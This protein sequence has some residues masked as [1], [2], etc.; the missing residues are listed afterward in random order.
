V[1][2]VNINGARLAYRV[3]GS[4]Q[5]PCVVL[6]HCLGSDSRMW[7][8][9]VAPLSRQ[10]RVVR[11]DCRGHGS[12]DLSNGQ[13]DIAGLGR[14]LV[15]LL[16]HLQIDRAHVCG[17]SLGGVIAQW[18]VVHYPERVLSAVFANTAARIGSTASWDA[19]IEAVR[20]RGMAG[21]C[22]TLIGR[23][24]STA[25]RARRPDVVRI[26][27]D[28]LQAT[29][30]EGYIAACA[31]LRDADLCA[32]VPSIRVPVLVIAGGLDEA[33]PPQQ[34]AELAAA[35]TGSRFIVLAEAAHLSNVEQPEAFNSGLLDF[36]G[37][38]T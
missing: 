29:R 31:A 13:V 30:P 9:Q 6:V 20:G 17:L 18:F 16:D 26:F 5:D 21:M 25:F 34:S 15:G 11:Y 23:F 4:D 3:D 2:T 10:L 27:S 1:N 19:R 28:I 33:T 37:G 32:V 24:F 35:I 38:H 7:K 12:S 36:F 14:D 8:A 22:D